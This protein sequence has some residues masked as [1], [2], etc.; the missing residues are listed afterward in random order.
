MSPK[1]ETSEHAAMVENRENMADLAA[2]LTAEQGKTLVD[3]AGDVFRGLA[4]VEAA[5]PI[6]TLQL[7]ELP[8]S[9]A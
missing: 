2:T 6:G 5:A 9:V 7:G 4:V 1:G 3:A 8:Q